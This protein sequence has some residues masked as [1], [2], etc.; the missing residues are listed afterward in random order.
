M[1]YNDFIIR[2]L[3][4]TNK[5]DILRSVRKRGFI[6]MF[7]S[8]IIFANMTMKSN[9]DKN[10]LTTKE[11]QLLNGAATVLL[12]G[13]LKTH[14]LYEWFIGECSHSPMLFVTYPSYQFIIKS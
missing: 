14:S 2:T 5:S 9:V 8:E 4:R 1:E 7:K 3:F 10:L 6:T 12:A 13:K 11:Q